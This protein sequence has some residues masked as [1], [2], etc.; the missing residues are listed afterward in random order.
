MHIVRHNQNVTEWFSNK[1]DWL[2]RTRVQCCFLLKL[3]LTLWLYTICFLVKLTKQLSMGSQHLTKYIVESIFIWI[4]LQLE[5]APH[6]CCYLSN[7]MRISEPE[8]SGIW[9]VNHIPQNNV[10]YNSLSMSQIP[11]S[12]LSLKLTR[13][14]RSSTC[15]SP[16]QIDTQII[17]LN[18]VKIDTCSV[19]VHRQIQIIIN[20]QF[21]KTTAKATF[22]W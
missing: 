12:G 7:E 21:H 18:L 16:R 5:T 4:M 15:L 20:S 1:N 14:V 22:R 8:V 9:I 10:G 11:A 17:I 6:P 3:E 19:V 2:G 13:A